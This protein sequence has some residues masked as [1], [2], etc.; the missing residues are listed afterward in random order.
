M[1]T[2]GAS[3]VSVGTERHDGAVAEGLSNTAGRQDALCGGS[4][5]LAASWAT[6]VSAAAPEHLLRAGRCE[7][8]ILQ[9]DVA[10]VVLLLLAVAIGS[11]PAVVTTEFDQLAFS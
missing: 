4:A 1:A 2:R 11:A 5:R 8:V 9:D 10:I 3:L 7:A 6:G